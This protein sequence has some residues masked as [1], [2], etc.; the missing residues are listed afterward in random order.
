MRYATHQFLSASMPHT[1][2][3]CLVHHFNHGSST[4]DQQQDAR[5]REVQRAVF[6]RTTMYTVHQETWLH[7]C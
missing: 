3:A 1:T 4:N 7:C 2:V 5:L 6:T